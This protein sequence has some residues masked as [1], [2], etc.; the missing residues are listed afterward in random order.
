MTLSFIITLFT[1]CLLG[2]MSP[3]PS[4]AVV[5]KHSLTGGR[6]YGIAVAWSHALGI[7]IYAFFTMSGLSILLTHSPMLF[8]AITYLG[9]AYLAYL[10]IRSLL[11]KG[12]LEDKLKSGNKVSIKQVM[13]DGLAISLLNPKIALFFI[14]LFSQFI[15]EANSVSMN[16]VIAFTPAILDGLWYTLVA[17]ILS[18]S[19]IIEHIRSKAS[20]IDK[21]TGFLLILLALKVVFN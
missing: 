17:I 13:I 2:A 18:N 8:K 12:G 6:L 11:S 15:N 9:A 19:A 1:I 7:L 20:V 10:G 3:G 4:L 5:A 21:V 16:L 14:A